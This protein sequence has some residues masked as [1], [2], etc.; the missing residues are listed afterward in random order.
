MQGADGDGTFSVKSLHVTSLGP[1]SYPAPYSRVAWSLE[2]L[3]RWDRT[4]G[5]K[6]RKLLM[7]RRLNQD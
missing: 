6:Q 7:S 1:L 5:Q 2:D 4:K 3:G